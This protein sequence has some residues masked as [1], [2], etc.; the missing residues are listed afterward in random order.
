MVVEMTAKQTYLGAFTARP[1]GNASLL[2]IDLMDGQVGVRWTLLALVGFLL[3]VVA[4]GAG[5]TRWA[6]PLRTQGTGTAWRGHP[7]DCIG[8]CDRINLHHIIDETSVLEREQKE[9][10]LP[11]PVTVQQSYVYV[12]ITKTT[13][14]FQTDMPLLLFCP[15]K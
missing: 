4:W 12:G 8:G 1:T 6:G 10:H 15:S 3:D 7:I 5:H 2:A 9:W 11:W 14:M 13:R